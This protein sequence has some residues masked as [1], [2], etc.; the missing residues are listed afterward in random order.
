VVWNIAM[1]GLFLC[2]ILLCR[3]YRAQLAGRWIVPSS[4]FYLSTGLGIIAACISIYV[5]FFGGSPV[6]TVSSGDWVF[7]V[8]LTV[9]ISLTIGGIYSFLVPEAEDLA[10]WEQRATASASVDSLVPTKAREAT[11]T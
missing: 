2:G 1:V 4:V 8:L 5:T 9:F 7:W 10:E 3:R 11:P 6:L